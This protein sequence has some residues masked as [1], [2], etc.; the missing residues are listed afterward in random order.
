MKKPNVG[1]NITLGNVPTIDNGMHI[2]SGNIKTYFQNGQKHRLRGPAE[3]HPDGTKIW[4]KNGVK[5]RVGGPAVENSDGTFEYWE[6]GKLISK[7][8]K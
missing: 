4:F 5:H 1:V 6:N 3:I 8:K 7:G 2:L